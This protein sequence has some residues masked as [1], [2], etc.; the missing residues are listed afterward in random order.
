MQKGKP[1][2]RN[3]MKSKGAGFDTGNA[4]FKAKATAAKGDSVPLTRVL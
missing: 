1:L 2:A 3:G 4:S